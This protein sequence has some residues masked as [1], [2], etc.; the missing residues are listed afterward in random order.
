MKR[1]KRVSILIE[2]LRF[3]ISLTASG[4]AEVPA[5]TSGED[6]G[7]KLEVGSISPLCPHCGAAWIAV[8]L[9]A[10]DA[11]AAGSDTVYRALQQHGLHVL[12][13]PAGQL[14]ICSKSLEKISSEETKESL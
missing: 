7:S 4:A 11:A 5:A 8:T 10:A 3:S 2:H 13:G 9:Q 6:G 12:T 1:T 14:N